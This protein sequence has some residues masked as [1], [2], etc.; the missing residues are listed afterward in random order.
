MHRIVIRGTSHER[1]RPTNSR[2]GGG[3]ITNLTKTGIEY[4][5][6]DLNWLGNTWKKEFNNR[7]LPSLNQIQNGLIAEAKVQ[8]RLACG[9]VKDQKSVQEAEANI[10]ETW[11]DLMS[12]AQVEDRDAKLVSGGFMRAKGLSDPNDSVVKL[13]GFLY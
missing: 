11:E 2:F 13:C 7:E 5:R 9:N 6:G 4:K 10:I 3:S 1:A 8:L 12:K